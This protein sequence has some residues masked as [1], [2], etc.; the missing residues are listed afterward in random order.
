M[1]SNSRRALSAALSVL[2]AATAVAAIAPSVASAA[3]KRIVALSPFTANTL[4]NL[5][6]KPVGVGQTLGGKDRLSPKLRGIRVLPLAHPNGPNLEQVAALNPDLVL[7]SSTW[8]RGHE[9]MRRLQ[10]R[11]VPSDPR[12]L[13]GMTTETLRIGRIVGRPAQA[14]R[15]AAALRRQVAAATKGI[16]SRPTVLVILG[17]G[18]TSFAFLPNSWGGDLIRRAGGRLLTEGISSRDGF[19]RISDEVILQRNPDVIIGVPHANEDDIP[20]IAE[21]M[22]RNPAWQSTNAVRNGRVYISTN[23][24][25]LQAN[26]DI[27]ATLRYIRKNYLR[28]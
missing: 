6:I 13:N 22:R 1:L 7:S 15:A 24:S 4:V 20:G 25:F 17:V 19:A 16:K 28:N 21:F 18:R 27:G 12:S 5:G 23:D 26:T 8:S 3:P 11:V 10:M 2:I 14:Q 9:A